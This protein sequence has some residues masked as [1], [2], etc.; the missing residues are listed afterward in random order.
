MACSFTV[1]QAN[2]IANITMS[3]IVI[4]KLNPLNKIFLLVKPPHSH[5]RQKCFYS[6][7]NIIELT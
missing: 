4:K 2:C 1:M 7:M 6:E 5:S 3:G